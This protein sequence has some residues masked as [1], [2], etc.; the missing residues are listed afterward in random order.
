[1]HFE[2]RPSADLGDQLIEL[3]ENLADDLGRFVSGKRFAAFGRCNFCREV[4]N[5]MHSTDQNV[6]KGLT[7]RLW[8]IERRY[9]RSHSMIRRGSNGVY[10]GHRFLSTTGRRNNRLAIGVLLPVPLG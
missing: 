9:R 1:M 5:R 10:E 8:I 2:E 4:L 6:A 3:F 7:T